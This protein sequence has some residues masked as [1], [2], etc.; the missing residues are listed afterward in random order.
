MLRL[1]VFYILFLAT[2]IFVLLFGE[3][4]AFEGT[5]IARAHNFLQDGLPAALSRGLVLL[6]GQRRGQRLLDTFTDVCVNRPNP[7]LQVVYTALVTAGYTVFLH[8]AW[9]LIPGNP[10]VSEIHW[11]ARLLPCVLLT[12]PPADPCAA[13]LVAV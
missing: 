3:C 10:Y 6:C 9:P 8:S 13:L 4:T 11:C 7:A 2:F 5:F 12:R 1:L